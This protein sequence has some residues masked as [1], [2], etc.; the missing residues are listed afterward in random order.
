M[1]LL[2]ILVLLIN[3]PVK[4]KI[5]LL[6]FVLMCVAKF[7]ISAQED[8]DP[9]NDNVLEKKIETIAENT[10]QDID[11]TNLFENIAYL[12]EHPLDLNLAS[13]QDFQQLLILNDFQI[14]QL[15]RHIALYGPL[16]SKFELQAVAGFDLATIYSILP[17]V[18]VG[19]DLNRLNIP[20]RVMIKN[21][22]QSIFMRVSQVLEEQ[23]GFSPISPEALE[24]N[25][26]A[27]FLG[28]P[29]R[30]FARYR[31]RYNNNL[32]MGFTAEKDAGEEF[33]K[34][35]QKRGFDF[36]SA[37]LYVGNIGKLKSA[38]VGDYLAQFGQGLTFW[39]GFAFGKT[40]DAMN[41]KRTGQGLRPYTS[42][43]ENLFLRGLATAW[44]F[45]KI[46]ATVFAS[47]RKVNTNATAIDSLSQDVG[48]FSSFNL[49]GFHRTFNEIADKANVQERIIGTHVAY[50]KRTFNVGVTAVQSFYDANLFRGNQPYNKFEFQGNQNL[51]IGSDF[52]WIWRNF[53][54]FGE[55]A[56]SSNGGMAATGGVIASLDPKL[57]ISLLHRNFGRDYQ[58]VYT[59]AI[60]EGSRSI[61]EIG[62]LLGLNYKPNR[63]ININAYID[64]FQ[65]PWLR[66]LINAPSNGNDA[67][68]QI[69]YTPNRSFDMYFR[70][71]NRTNPRNTPSTDL[72]L[73]NYPIGRNQQNFRYDVSYKIS[74]SFK[75]R[76]RIE[77]VLFNPESGIK[78][79]GIM[80]MQ[81]V[82]YR[83]L[84]SP[85]QI[86]ARYALFDTDGFNSRI[87][88]F[89][90]D[91]LYSF[92]I[93]AYFYKGSRSYITLEYNATRKIDIWLR[94]AQFHFTNRN[95]T[96]TGL[97][98]VQG[99]VRTEIRAQI[100][101]KF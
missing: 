79:R 65:F 4:K 81:D 51:N 76:N 91:V 45:G 82:F 21:A 46:E 93:P 55:V 14:L 53:N 61:N 35:T 64:R 56:R 73:I 90:N 88:A 71:R 9:R 6:L 84:N 7:N 36:Y 25:P 86:S 75:L 41:V 28:N 40:A 15:Q 42:V 37:H 23:K 92:S 12:Q 70:Y 3:S 31:F 20:L 67:L 68:F 2:R 60:A 66:Y 19:R 50:K 38:V 43:N 47:S 18:K 83:K 17:Y 11:Y 27:R 63:A 34:G 78:E 49:G 57:S 5:K 87:Y 89:E 100:R 33:F 62:T 97:T 10:E 99:P 39:S 16:L 77:V 24:A 94:W 58:A 85:F 48:L 30:I 74:P 26:N 95:I 8:M 69:N 54:I 13:A 32:S 59:A 101:Y 29:Q 44:Q 22:N 1:V 98:E 52:N 96:G 80:V 72:D